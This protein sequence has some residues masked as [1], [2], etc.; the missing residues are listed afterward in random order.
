MDPITAALLGQGISTVGG[1]ALNKLFGGQQQPQQTSLL[2]PQQQELQ[3]LAL[4]QALEQLRGGSPTAGIEDV[5]RRQ[6]QERTIPSIAERFTS[7]GIP[8][9]SSAF[10]SSLGRA[11]AGLEDQLAQLRY[12]AQ[13]NRLAQLLNVGFGSQPHTAIPA[14]QQTF[15][16]TVGSQLP[17]TL[18]PLLQQLL[19]GLGGQQSQQQAAPTSPGFSLSGF[20][21]LGGTDYM[22]WYNQFTNPSA[23]MTAGRGQL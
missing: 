21:P 15:G 2:N 5:A 23:F 7:M 8:Q 10:A 11:G 9:S 1:F 19:Q 14:Q 13:E 16:Q 18:G 20:G 6:F 17:A 4:S 12:G 3:N 22:N